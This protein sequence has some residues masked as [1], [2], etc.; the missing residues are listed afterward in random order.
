LESQ[1]FPYISTERNNIHILDLVQSAQLLK[2]ANKYI[3]LASK[4]EKTFLFIATKCQA[5]AKIAQEAIRANSFYINHRW[6]GS[7]L[8]NWVTLKSR[9]GCLKVLEQQEVD[10]QLD[11]MPKKEAIL[12]RKELEKL[13]DRS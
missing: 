6:L 2:E 4:Q 3:Y 11:I 7:M 10:G 5:S 12:C 13:L 8:T 9:I 1:N